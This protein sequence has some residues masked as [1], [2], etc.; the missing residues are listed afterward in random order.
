M[1]SFDRSR[2]LSSM[3]IWK[4]RGAFLHFSRGIAQAIDALIKEGP[5]NLMGTTHKD[6]F[7]PL[8]AQVMMPLACLVSY[9][10]L[11]DNEAGLFKGPAAGKPLEKQLYVE[12]CHHKGDTGKKQEE[13]DDASDERPA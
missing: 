8:R 6:Y 3:M 4:Q 5:V 2:S 7:V 1:A 13:N 10:V 9:S 12:I 11:V